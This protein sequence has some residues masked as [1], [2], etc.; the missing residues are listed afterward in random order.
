MT[1]RVSCQTAASRPDHADKI[2]APRLRKSC[3]S[4]NPTSSLVLSCKKELPFLKKSSKK[5]LWDS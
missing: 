1:A 4:L 2:K 5:L 3:Q